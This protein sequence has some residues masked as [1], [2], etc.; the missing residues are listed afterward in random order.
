MFRIK[1]V[2]N[3]TV[4]KQTN[5]NNNNPH[6]AVPIP[7]KPAPQQTFNRQSNTRNGM[8]KPKPAK[9]EQT[10]PMKKEMNQT[11]AV[12][13]QRRINLNP[14]S[15]APQLINTNKLQKINIKHGNLNKKEVDM[16]KKEVD[17]NKKQGNL[18]KKDE[19]E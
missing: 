10:K 9:I 15:K 5:I 14:E 8:S 7:L 12:G 1:N 6:V 3:S 18:N 19:K 11:K 13:P 4:A 2:R 16:H 17:S